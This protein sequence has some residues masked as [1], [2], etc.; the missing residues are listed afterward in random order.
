[1]NQDCK[2]IRSYLKRLS[3]N[4]AEAYLSKFNLPA[5]NERIMYHLYVKKVPDIIQVKYRLEEE[6]IFISDFKDE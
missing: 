3:P 6:G 5:V 4:N 1:M 2:V